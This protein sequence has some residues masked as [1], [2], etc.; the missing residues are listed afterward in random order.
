M[1]AKINCSECGHDKGHTLEH[2]GHDTLAECANCDHVNDVLG[3]II[4]IE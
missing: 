3:Y 4:V 1:I 2:V